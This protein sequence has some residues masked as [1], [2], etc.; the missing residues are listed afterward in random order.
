MKK[1][2]YRGLFFLPTPNG[3]IAWGEEYVFS[4]EDASCL[5]IPP[6]GEAGNDSQDWIQARAAKR[7]RS[8]E[9]M[10]ARDLIH[11]LATVERLPIRR[12]REALDWARK[13]IRFEFFTEGAK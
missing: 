6:D 2:G 1:I 7:V 11:Y 4:P 12:N 5:P 3:D 13:A 9:S 10:M 8:V